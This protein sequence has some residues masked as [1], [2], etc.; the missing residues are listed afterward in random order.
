MLDV[1]GSR[2]LQAALLTVR[3]AEREL[4]LDINKDARK[5][6]SGQWR[7]AVL[8]FAESRTDVRILATGARA[9]VGVRQVSLKAATSNRPLRGGLVPS[10]DWAAQEFGMRNYKK[11]FTTTS[12]RGTR[13]QVTKTIGRQFP[14]RQRHG[15]VVF[16]AASLVGTRLVAIWVRTIVNKF[17]SIAEITPR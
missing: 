13:Y 15:R 14:G 16:N 5:E 17:A 3:T 2:E 10:K 11:T 4:R 6:I 9:A 1:Q 12:R 8:G 7:E